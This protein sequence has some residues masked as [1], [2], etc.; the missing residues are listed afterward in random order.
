MGK[1]LVFNNGYNDDTKDK[2]Y[3]KKIKIQLILMK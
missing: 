1:E 2:Y 3:F